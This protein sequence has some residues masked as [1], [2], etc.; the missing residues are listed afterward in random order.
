MSMSTVTGEDP[1]DI[2]VELA[3]QVSGAHELVSALPGL[4]AGYPATVR[5]DGPGRAW[6]DFHRPMETFSINA[7]ARNI[8]EES[9]RWIRAFSGLVCVRR[10][11]GGGLTLHQV[12]FRFLDGR[13]CAD[14]S[15]TIS[16]VRAEWPGLQVAQADGKSAFARQL[17][18]VNRSPQ[19]CE[20]LLLLGSDLVSWPRIYDVLEFLGRDTLSGM[21]LLSKKQFERIRRTANHYRHLG[22]QRDYSLPKDPPTL[23][24]ASSQVLDVVMRYL[25]ETLGGEGGDFLVTTGPQMPATGP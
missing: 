12:T 23:A 10:G 4:L 20:L 16:V 15:I 24:E 1:R 18:R 17:E 2:V 25:E 22:G 21:G 7:A 11:F 3:L 19:A 13:R 9:D 8:F 14:A 6:I 5:A